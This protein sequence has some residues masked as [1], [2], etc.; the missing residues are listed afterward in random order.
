MEQEEDKRL[1]ENNRAFVD[2][3]AKKK[4]LVVAV[5]SFFVFLWLLH[6]VAFSSDHIRNS[7][8]EEDDDDYD[9][10]DALDTDLE[11]SDF[12]MHNAEMESA[13]LDTSQGVC[14]PQACFRPK[15]FLSKKD[16]VDLPFK[17]FTLL[18]SYPGSGKPSIGAR[19]SSQL[20]C[21]RQ[22]HQHRQH[23]GECRMT[24]L[25]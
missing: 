22:P 8:W 25:L 2:P 1:V 13:T 4:V 17:P 11:H 6:L 3:Q 9:G 16:I 23:L 24:I 5:C 21:Q 12:S 20:T 14:V 15:H 7:K 10:E 18:A 19:Q